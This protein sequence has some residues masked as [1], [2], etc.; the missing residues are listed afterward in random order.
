[1]H[2][3]SCSHLLCYD[4]RNEELYDSKYCD[5][6]AGDRCV[7]LFFWTNRSLVTI[8]TC[9]RVCHILKHMGRRQWSHHDDIKKSKWSITDVGVT[10][11]LNC[12]QG[13]LRKVQRFHLKGTFSVTYWRGRV[14]CTIFTILYVCVARNESERAAHPAWQISVRSFVSLFTTHD[15]TI[16]WQC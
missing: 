2:S 9:S 12:I 16:K 8:K 3:P 7:C 11:T 5:G 4:E 10:S 14:D 6:L 15:R 13:I 1:M